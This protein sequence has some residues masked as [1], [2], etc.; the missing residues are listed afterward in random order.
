MQKAFVEALSGAHGN[1]KNQFEF[2]SE[3]VIERS[4]TQFRIHCGNEVIAAFQSGGC[5]SIGTFG[6]SYVIA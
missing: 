1:A 4:E 3:G 6:G 2:T 5:K